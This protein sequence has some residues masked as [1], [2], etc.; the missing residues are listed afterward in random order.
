[1]GPLGPTELIIILVIVLVLFGAKRLPDLG[2]SLGSGMREFKDAVTP[3]SKDDDRDRGLEQGPPPA[4]T[5]QQAQR[6]DAPAQP[7]A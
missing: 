2:K 6:E 4:Q 5:T 3:G 1:M 7:R